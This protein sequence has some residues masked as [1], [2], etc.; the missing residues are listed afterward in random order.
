MYAHEI[1]DVTIDEAYE[2]FA[3]SIV[4][5][6]VEDYRKVLHGQK[7][8][9][10]RVVKN[11]RDEIEHFFKSEWCYQLLGYS[12]VRIMNLI[13]EQEGVEKC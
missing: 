1:T 4:I 8:Q 11:D 12:G 2:H 7:I 5:Q 6:A 10:Y 13:R 3:A 9:R